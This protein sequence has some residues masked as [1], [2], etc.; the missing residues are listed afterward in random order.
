[1]IITVFRSVLNDAATDD[2]FEL[3]PHITELAKTMPGFVSVKTFLAEDGERCTIVEFESQ[4]T[5]QAWAEHAEHREAQQRGRDAFYASY[6]LKVAEV[7]RVSS[8]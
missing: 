4:E 2:Y 7:I 3:S 6:D 8:K 5:H 1:M